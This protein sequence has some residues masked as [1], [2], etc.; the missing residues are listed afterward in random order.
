M[1]ERLHCFCCL[2]QAPADEDGTL[3]R[4][5]FLRWEYGLIVSRRRA[6]TLHLTRHLA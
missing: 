4:A 1:L 2:R 5:E 3:G 6:Q